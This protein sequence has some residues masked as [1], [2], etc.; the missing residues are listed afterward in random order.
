MDEFFK[1]KNELCVSR[2]LKERLLE[3]DI[4]D[5]SRLR[6]IRSM[7]LSV[8]HDMPSQAAP[9]GRMLARTRVVVVTSADIRP[10]EL[11]RIT[12][13]AWN[14]SKAAGPQFT[15]R[16]DRD[17]RTNVSFRHWRVID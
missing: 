2:D 11:Q 8:L 17:A 1:L 15:H 16:V 5:D 14:R 9:I 3:A 4:A 6:I 12:D 7:D 10:Q 13:Y